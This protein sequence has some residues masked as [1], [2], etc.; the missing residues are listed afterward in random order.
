M[1][2]ELKPCHCPFCGQTPI[3]VDKTLDKDRPLMAF[4]CPPESS[5][6]GSNL[7][8]VFFGE[9]KDKAIAAWNRRAPAATVPRALFDE[10]CEQTEIIDACLAR[11]LH[12]STILTIVKE[13]LAALRAQANEREVGK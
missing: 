2:E 5:C 8:I 3:L 9:D 12:A 1:K 10:A 11:G 13:K 6:R 4:V 7:I